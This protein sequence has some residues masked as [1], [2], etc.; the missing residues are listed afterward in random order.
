M[1][2]SVFEMVCIGIMVVNAFLS[3]CSQILLKKSSLDKHSSLWQEYINWR[4]MTAYLIYVYVLLSNAFAYQ[5]VAYK[6]GSIIGTA[7]YFFLMLLSKLM[8][9][10]TISRKTI[11]GNIIIV[12][13]MIVYACKSC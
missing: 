5:G 12:T 2:R 10:E 6:Y 1:N 9:K 4:V 7:S 3:A 8:L 11:I 13:G